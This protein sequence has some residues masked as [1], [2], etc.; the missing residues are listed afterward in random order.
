MKLTNK[1]WG[2]LE[3]FLLSGGLFLALLVAIFLISKLYG[4]MDGAFANGQ[5]VD[6]EN[7]IEI[8]AQ[9][10]IESNEIE[11]NVQYKLTLNTLKS[12]NFINELKDKNGNNCNGY[13][14]IINNGNNYSYKG[15]VSCNGY[16]TKDY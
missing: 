6:L 1:G 15:Y 8:A 14:L 11:I 13:V 16:Q 4:S 7:K 12:N 5:Y 2:T 10:Y 9:N 3:M